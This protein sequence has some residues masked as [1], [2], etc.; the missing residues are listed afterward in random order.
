MKL[1]TNEAINRLRA[2]GERHT[3]L[4]KNLALNLLKNP[5]AADALIEGGAQ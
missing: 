3:E 1:K 2:E 5:F 4:A